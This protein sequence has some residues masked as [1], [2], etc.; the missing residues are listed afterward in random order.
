MKK[1]NKKYL[2]RCTWCSLSDKYD[3][4]PEKGK[5][6]CPYCGNKVFVEEK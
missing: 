6:R 2:I 1:K 5:F 3:K 4:I